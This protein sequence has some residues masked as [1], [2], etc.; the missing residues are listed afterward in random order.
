MNKIAMASFRNELEKN[1]SLGS[2]MA[3]NVM[4][5]LHKPISIVGG[6]FN[7]YFP[8]FKKGFAGLG[9]AL[10]MGATGAAGVGAYA[11]YKGMKEPPEVNMSGY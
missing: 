2:L 11:L 10:A 9:N 5:F 1:S 4:P 8:T 6:S 7:K 3:T